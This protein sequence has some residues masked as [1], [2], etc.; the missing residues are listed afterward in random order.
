MEEQYGDR[1]EQYNLGLLSGAE[2]ERFEAEMLADPKLAEA[3]YEHRTAWEIGELLAE[4]HLRA[5]IRE[6]FAAPPPPL[7]SVKKKKIWST[8]S[9]TLLALFGTAGFLFWL[10]RP[11]AP[12]EPAKSMPT[13]EISPQKTPTG[14]APQQPEPA[15]PPR[16]QP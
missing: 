14:P 16:L 15:P 1:I 8:T 9:L 6:R 10:N 7:Q 13:P 4:E 2:L 11:N 3:V 12:P 5:Q